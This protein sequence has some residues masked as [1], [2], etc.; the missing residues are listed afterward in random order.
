M[1]FLP[2]SIF[3]RGIYNN[4]RLLELEDGSKH[5]ISENDFLYN[6]FPEQFIE[7]KR[8]IY[9]STKTTL[10]SAYDKKGGVKIKPEYKKYVTKELENEI[11]DKLGNISSHAEGMVENADKS[12]VHLHTALSTILMFR[13]FLPKNIENTWNPAYWNYQTKELAIGTAMAYWY[14]WLYGANN[15]GI[16]AIR[17]LTFRNKEKDISE[18]SDRFNVSESYT[19]KQIETYAK[20]FNAQVFTYI[21]WLTLFNALGMIGSTGPDDDYWYQNVLMLELKK[22]SLESGS[23]YNVMDIADIFNSVSPLL[24]TVEDIGTAFGPWSYFKERKYKKIKKGAF[25]GLYGWQRDFIKVI[26]WL[27]AYYN[28]KNPGEKLRD[29]QNRIGG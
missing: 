4:Y 15:W 17:A 23:R 18:L 12:G 10:W 21:F 20:R 3:M 5:F 26:P 14:G 11:S 29:L 13:A 7:E 16:K 27:N 2:N 22:I 25:K 9:N 8:A 19:R 6:H 24:Q 1:S 28:M